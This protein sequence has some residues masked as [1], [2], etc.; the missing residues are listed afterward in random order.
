MREE[1]YVA[2]DEFVIRHGKFPT[3]L[4]VG[5]SSHTGLCQSFSDAEGQEVTNLQGAKVYGMTVH[6][7]PTLTEFAIA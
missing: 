2:R 3:L 7:V 1:I 6:L 4:F 5:P